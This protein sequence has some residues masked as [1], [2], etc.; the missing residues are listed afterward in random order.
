[1]GEVME[2]PKSKESNRSQKAAAEAVKS[3]QY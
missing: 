1:M 3:K 2:G